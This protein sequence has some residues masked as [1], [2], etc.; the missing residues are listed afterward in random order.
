MKLP[1]LE[2]PQNYTGLYVVDYRDVDGVDGCSVGYTAEEVAC[3]LESEP[4]SAC[5]VYRIVRARPDG[6]LELQGVPA[7]RFQLESGMVF[8]CR[9][10]AT[11]QAGYRQICD[12]A[13]EQAS[14]CRVKLELARGADD[15]CVLA[16]IYPAEAEADVGRWLRDSGWRGDGPVDA[17]VGAVDR[18]YGQDPVVVERAQLWPEAS[19][20]ARDRETLRAAAGQAVQR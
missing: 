12:W 3:L 9:I 10:E 20:R 18:Y 5:K 13:V 19:R 16:L 4:W 15:R 7:E 17:G 14:P 6:Q 2:Q 8:H 11:A 1:E